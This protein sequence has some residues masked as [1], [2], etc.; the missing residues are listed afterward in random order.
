L[1]GVC[2][3]TARLRFSCYQLVGNVYGHP[4]SSQ[5]LT[6]TKRSHLASDLDYYNLH[7]SHPQAFFSTPRIEETDFC[8]V[9]ESPSTVT[10]IIS[11]TGVNMSDTN[12]RE[13]KVHTVYNSH[14][15]GR[16]RLD[17]EWDR[18]SKL[19]YDG[20]TSVKLYLKKFDHYVQLIESLDPDVPEKDILIQL[21]EQLI[22]AKKPPTLGLDGERYEGPE[23]WLGKQPDSNVDTYE[24]LKSA[25]MERYGGHEKKSSLDVIQEIDR[26]H[27]NWKKTTLKEFFTDIQGIIGS[28][29][30]EDSFVIKFLNEK[31]PIKIKEELRRSRGA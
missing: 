24:K 19:S 15:P 3:V 10:D 6:A 22:N 17:R 9:V 30:V 21:I 28:M 20:T 31:L 13:E 18:L 25:L 5:T 4:P 8:G 2:V 14:G 26:V 16:A 23:T 27:P 7:E 11:D 1:P 12:E 29:K